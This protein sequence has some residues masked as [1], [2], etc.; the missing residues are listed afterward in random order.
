MEIWKNLIKFAI[1]IK[2][3]LRPFSFLKIAVAIYLVQSLTA[4]ANI[5]PPSGGPRDSLPPY[6]IVAKPK[7]SATGVSPKEIMI[8]FNE[9]INTVSLNENLII[10]PSLKNI[11][12]VESKLNTLRI[13][14]NDTLLPNTTYRI[15]FGNAIRDVN[16]SNIA[17]DFSF[18][19]STGDH[20]DSNRLQG[21]VTVA[22]TGRIDSSLIVVLHPTG[23]DSAIFKNR[24]LYYA[25]VN[26]KGKFGFDFLPNQPF[27]IFV[28]PNDYTK[29]YDDCTKLFAFLA[30]PVI[31]NNSKDSIRL[32]AFQAAPKV[33]KKKMLGANTKPAK[34]NTPSLKYAKGQDGNEQDLLNPLRLVFETPVHLNDSFPILLYD[35]NFKPIEDINVYIDSLAPNSL[36]VSTEWASATKYKLVIPQNSIKDTLNNKLV[37]TDTLTFITKPNKAY[38]SCVVRISG[39]DLNTKPVLLLTQDDKIKFSFPITQ[40]LLNIPQ[41]PAGEF[42]LKILEDNNSNGKWD[43][44]KYAIGSQ[45]KQPEKIYLLPNKLTIRADWDNELNIT[46]K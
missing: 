25:K 1:M 41:L 7:D 33:E 19:F 9:Y 24:P 36:V 20:I 37:K 5:V 8:G 35:T 28:L 15:Q 18:V 45:S 6:R 26:G 42:Q 13:R 4:C 31:A 22:E 14:I 44:G 32:F 43:T 46:I 34:R 17:Q 2:S 39:L 29:R 12:L 3:L 40:N 23:K 10:G 30:Q 21:T 38:G 27:N 16:E 11:P